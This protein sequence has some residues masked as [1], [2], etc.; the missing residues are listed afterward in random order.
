MDKN[1]FG[2][3]Q[4]ANILAEKLDRLNDKDT[5]RKISTIIKMLDTTLNKTI[6]SKPEEIAV[7]LKDAYF[8]KIDSPIIIDDKDI[9]SYARSCI[10]AKIKR[11]VKYCFEH[12]A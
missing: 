5:T 4:S 1:T 12:T 3:H 9:K 11:W 6:S 2:K 8:K 7:L 10:N